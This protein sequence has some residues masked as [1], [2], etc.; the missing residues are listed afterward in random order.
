MR[1]TVN[2]DP[3]VLDAARRALG[4][5][6]MSETVNAALAEVARRMAIKR[7]DVRLFDVTDKDIALSRRDRLTG[8][9]S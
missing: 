1:T 9:Q 6:G 5:R 7:F 2:I 8:D 3:T 4:T